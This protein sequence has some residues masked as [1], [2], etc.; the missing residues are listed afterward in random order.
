MRTP[1]LVLVLAS[2]MS[3]LAAGCASTPFSPNI[4]FEPRAYPYSPELGSDGPSSAG[5]ATK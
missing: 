1:I 4:A 2:I 3:I 5:L